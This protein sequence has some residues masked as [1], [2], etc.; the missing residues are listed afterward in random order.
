MIKEINGYKAKYI[1][2][3]INNIGDCRVTIYGHNRIKD[4]TSCLI[5]ETNYQTIIDRIEQGR[6]VLL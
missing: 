5:D 1:V 6:R 2:E 4:G 3:S